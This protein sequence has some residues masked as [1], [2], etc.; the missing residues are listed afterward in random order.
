MQ[1]DVYIVYTDNGDIVGCFRTQ[2][3]AVQC[4]KEDLMTDWD[5][6]DDEEKAR[7]IA[8]LEEDG[9]IDG[10]YYITYAGELGD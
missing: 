2:A 9:C 7:M 5:C 6:F 8:E 3:G 4:I 10:F 1:I